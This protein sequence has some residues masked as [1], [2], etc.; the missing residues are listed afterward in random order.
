MTFLLFQILISYTQ[1]IS[2][3]GVKGKV[4]ENR[5]KKASRFKNLVEMYKID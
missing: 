3:N 1:D 5:L 4:V 2:S